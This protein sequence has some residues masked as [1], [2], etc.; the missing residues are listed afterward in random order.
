MAERRLTDSINYDYSDSEHVVVTPITN[1][2]DSSDSSSSYFTPS[3][4]IEQNRI[5]T[6][7][8]SSSKCAV[9]SKLAIWENKSNKNDIISRSRAK[10]K[11]S[12]SVKKNKL[13]A[14]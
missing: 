6:K 12:R 3:T 7:K 10:S 8:R 5:N 9:A 11:T 13:A 1:D 4:S 2:D 14:R